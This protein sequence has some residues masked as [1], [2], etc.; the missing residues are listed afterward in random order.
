MAVRKAHEFSEAAALITKDEPII[1]I[2]YK[3]ARIRTQRIM[4]DYIEAMDSLG[5][6]EKDIVA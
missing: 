5:A 2:K 4:G 3:L 6:L 1:N